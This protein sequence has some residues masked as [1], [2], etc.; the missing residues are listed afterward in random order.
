MKKLLQ[1]I[2][3]ILGIFLILGQNI[4]ISAQNE[5][6]TLPYI[7]TPLTIDGVIDDWPVSIDYTP[8]THYINKT[9][10]WVIQG[11][12]WSKD[13]FDQADLSAQMLVAYDLEYF[14]LFLEVTDD[15][16]AKQDAKW[17]SDDVELFFN[18]DPGNDIP[19]D[20]ENKNYTGSDGVT[21]AL[22]LTFPRDTVAFVGGP[23]WIIRDWDYEF[24]VVNQTSSYTFEIKLPWDSLFTD[25]TNIGD[26]IPDRTPLIVSA[27]PGY[28][29]GFDI[30]ITDYDGNETFEDHN[31]DGH[32]QWSNESGID[33]CYMNTGL[34]GTITLDPNTS[35]IKNSLDK[36][37]TYPSPF[38]E[39]LNI[40]GLR[41]GQNIQIH[42]L[43]GQKVFSLKDVEEKT[44]NLNLNKLEK[45]I[46][47]LGIYD[48]TGVVSSSKIV[49]K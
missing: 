22:Q 32:L 33:L 4:R 11:E 47:I 31:R 35:T 36:I 17:K 34:F 20:G 24:A 41:K 6:L 21:D 18:P 28:T 37:S 14:Y 44:I 19:F 26:W 48:D 10:D 25:H 8:L 7:N 2:V 49:K 23:G 30:M 12:Q 27:E 13:P 45:G 3:F 43:L 1:I 42:N 39:N 15:I 29:M 9:K 5:S 46:Y 38:S 16:D 40:K